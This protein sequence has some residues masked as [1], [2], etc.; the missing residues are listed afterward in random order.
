MSDFFFHCEKCGANGTIHAPTFK[1]A[2]DVLRAHGCGQTIRLSETPILLP[3]LP[4]RR[5]HKAESSPWW[6]RLLNMFTSS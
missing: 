6:R 2:K 3:L 1:D 4:R 5:A